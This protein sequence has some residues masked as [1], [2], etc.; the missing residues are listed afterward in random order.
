MK[1][2]RKRYYCTKCKKR[3]NTISKICG[4]HRAFLVTPE[5]Q[6]DIISEKKFEELEAIK[7]LKRSHPYLVV[8]NKKEINCIKPQILDRCPIVNLEKKII[9]LMNEDTFKKYLYNGV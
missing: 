4:K 1:R 7:K 2:I 9:L 6:L 3:H 8:I 5:K